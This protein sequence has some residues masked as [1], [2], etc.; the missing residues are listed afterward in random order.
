V[1]SRIAEGLYW[2]GRYAERA[3]DTARLLEVA[4]RATLE[5]S[6]TAGPAALAGVLGGAEVSG[7]RGEVLAHYCLSGAPPSIAT[8]VRRARQNARTIRESVSSEMWE[9]LNTWHL[10]TQATPATRLAGG[11]MSTFLSDVKQ[12]AYVF[13]GATHGTML[14]DEGW[15]WL[16]MGRHLERLVFTCRM[17]N[18]R[19]GLLAASARV[20]PTVQEQYAASMLLRS[21]SAYEPYRRTYQAAIRP[22]RV[23]EFLLFDADFPRSLVRCGVRVA[24]CADQ[25]GLADGSPVPRLA[26]RL[27][28]ELQ[29]REIREVMAEGLGAYVQRLG[30]LAEE[31][32]EAVGES[33]FARGEH[34]PA[35]RR[36]V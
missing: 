5:G 19:E 18:A 34:G 16:S 30:A 1:L 4:H 31:L 17:L 35:V 21:L 6:D 15:L 11:G 25:V 20:S 33:A 27:A 12:S 9:A 10:Q 7:T 36:A 14:R 29:Y 26:G 23:A 2:L 28:A 8:C 13:S 32:H 22:V 3:E 24:S